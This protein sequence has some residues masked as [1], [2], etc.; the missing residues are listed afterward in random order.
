MSLDFEKQFYDDKIRFIA[1]CDEAGRG[2]LLGP[3]VAACCILPPNFECDLINDSKK[4]NKKQRENA[5]QIIKNNALG[6]GIGIVDPDEIDAINIY[7]ASK[8]A[9]LIALSNVGHEFQLVLTDYMPLIGSGYQYIDMVKGDAKALCIA[10]AS[11][12][13]KVYRDQMMEQLDRKYPQYQI[14]KH[15]GYGTKLHIEL[16]KKYGPIPHVHRYSF[17]P[18]KKLVEEQIKLF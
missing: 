11:I 13:A 12:V 7:E 4:L 17:K 3:V 8:K 6:I 5:Y 2:P 16:L 18:V 10:A 14:K 1:G 9:M 15:K